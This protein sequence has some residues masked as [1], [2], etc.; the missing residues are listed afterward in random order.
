MKKC[1]KCKKELPATEEYFGYRTDAKILRAMCKDCI[2]DSKKASY[3]KNRQAYIDRAV[4]SRKQKREEIKHLS[5]EL[6]EV[7]CKDCGKS[8]PHYVMDFDHVGEKSNK[9]SNIVANASK[10][11][12]LE[13]VA[14]CEV[15]CANCHRERTFQRNQYVSEKIDKDSTVGRPREVK[16][17]FLQQTL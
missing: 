10:R 14:K 2:G 6:K 13:E 17:R 3:Q 1:N 16:E 12:F 15:V 7:P 4:V 9:I 11:L 8:Y 5:K